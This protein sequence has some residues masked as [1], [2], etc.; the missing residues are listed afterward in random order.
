MISLVYICEKALVRLDSVIVDSDQ[1][2]VLHD[3]NIAMFVL[4]WRYDVIDQ[5][6][7]FRTQ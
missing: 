7:V 1:Y 4:S 5:V 3:R 6:K 2:G